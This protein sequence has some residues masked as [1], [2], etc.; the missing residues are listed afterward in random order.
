MIRITGSYGK[1]MIVMA[2]QDTYATTVLSF[3]ARLPA[4][5]FLAPMP[6]SKE[7][8]KRDILDSFTAREVDDRFFVVYTQCSVPLVLEF[9]NEAMEEVERETNTAVTFVLVHP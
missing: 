2:I 4:M 5:D 8:A 1:G 6:R 3:V 7:E 9:I